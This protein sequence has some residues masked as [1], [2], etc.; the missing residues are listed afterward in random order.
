ME[1]K[2]MLVLGCHAVDFVWRAGGTIAAYADK[3]WEIKIIDMSFGERGEAEGLWASKEGITEEEIKARCKSDATAAAKALGASIAF[4]DWGDHPLEIDRDRVLVLAKEIKLFRPDIIL[5]QCEKDPWNVDHTAASQA[6]FKAVRLARVAGV[7]PELPK[8]KLPAI[9]LFDTTHPEFVDFNPD[10]FI[11]ITDY[12]DK[13]VE[14]MTHASNIQTYLVEQHK[15]RASYRATSARLFS[16]D[17]SIRYAEAFVRFAPY[18][19][20]QFH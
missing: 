9:F 17:K 18:V 16:G 14:A 1:N 4:L 2:K 8:V 19:G 12:I 15:A 7:F 10:V 13:K 20:K 11:D 5:T 6:V 3:G